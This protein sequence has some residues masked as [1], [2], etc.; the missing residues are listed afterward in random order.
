M[1]KKKYGSEGELGIF[2]GYI[3]LLIVIKFGMV[4]IVK[5]YGYEEIIY[6]FGGIVEI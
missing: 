4:C 2:Y 1:V 3:L 6:V 5:L